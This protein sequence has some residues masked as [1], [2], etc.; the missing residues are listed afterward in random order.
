MQKKRSMRLF[1][2]SMTVSLYLFVLLGGVLTAEYNT[3]RV[4]FGDTVPIAQYDQQEQ[5]LKFCVFGAGWDIDLSNSDL[6]FVGL[7]TF[8]EVLGEIEKNL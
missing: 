2:C 8:L 3:R 5:R 1:L 4:S 7:E 6:H